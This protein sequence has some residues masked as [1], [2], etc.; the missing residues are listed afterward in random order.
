MKVIGFDYD[1]TLT[2]VEPEKANAF[3]STLNAEWNVNSKEASNF[4]LSQGG[5][6][7]RFKFDHF[8]KQQYSAGLPDEI[9]EEVESKFSQL[10]KGK[11]YPDIKLLPHIEEVLSFSKDFFD[12]TFVASG[13]PEKELKYLIKTSKIGKYFNRVMGTND[14][15][16][17]KKD[18][19]EEI[20]KITNPSIILFVGDSAEDM[21][22]SKLSDIVAIGLT[23]NHSGEVLKKAGADF[24]CNLENLQSTIGKV[25]T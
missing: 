6:S 3:A 9:Y 14:T 22:M 15:Y 21:K 11:Y 7:R 12:F 5:T 2:N 1:G 4:W 8:Y 13:V 25:I 17:N 16:K 19:F 20:K 24:V 18:Q 23:T 10:L